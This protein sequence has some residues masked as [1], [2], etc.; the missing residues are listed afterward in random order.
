MTSSLHFSKTKVIKLT[1]GTEAED[2]GVSDV[3]M[4]SSSKLR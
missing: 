2:D 1:G 4:L 3:E